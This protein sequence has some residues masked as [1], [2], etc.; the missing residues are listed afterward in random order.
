M[1]SLRTTIKSHIK[2][3]PEE[4]NQMRQVLLWSLTRYA[5]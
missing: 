4:T 1:G 5:G 2:S 3:N